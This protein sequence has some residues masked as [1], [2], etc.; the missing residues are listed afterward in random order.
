VSTLAPSVMTTQFAQ[1]FMIGAGL[2]V[3]SSVRTL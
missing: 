3:M 2:A 1:R